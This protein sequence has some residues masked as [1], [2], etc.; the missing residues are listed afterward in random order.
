MRDAYV[1]AKSAFKHSLNYRSADIYDKCE[2]VANDTSEKIEAFHALVD[3][4]D[5]KHCGQ[6]NATALLKLPSIE[7]AVKIR[8]EPLNDKPEDV[9][10]SVWAGVVPIIYTLAQPIE[11][12]Y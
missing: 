1:F 5:T 10:L 8:L 9:N 2:L 7:A 12:N 3:L 4:Y 11:H 6:M